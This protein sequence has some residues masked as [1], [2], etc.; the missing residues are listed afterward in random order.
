MAS[1]TA[2]MDETVN[3]GSLE[4]DPAVRD[5]QLLHDKLLN[6]KNVT[7]K[8]ALA[9]V[10]NNPDSSCQRVTDEFIRFSAIERQFQ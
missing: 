8:A 9:T 1:M 7:S 10:I 2:T 3:Q 6:K 5:L 4:K